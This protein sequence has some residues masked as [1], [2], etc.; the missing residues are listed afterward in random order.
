MLGSIRENC[1]VSG[2]K[3]A[4]NRGHQNAL[5]AESDDRPGTGGLRHLLDA[6][7]QDD[8]DV[9]DAL[10]GQHATKA[11]KVVSARNKREYRL[12]LFK[13]STAQGFV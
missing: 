6:D 3:L 1:L 7:L 12:T 8:I 11:A 9:L 5:L 2:L 13:R 10:L 4:H